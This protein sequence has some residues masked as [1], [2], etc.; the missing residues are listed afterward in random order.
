MK[1]HLG[2]M[3]NV[4]FQSGNLRED[5][6][7]GVLPRRWN[8]NIVTNMTIAGQRLAKHVLALY[9]VN[10]NRRPFLDN[11]FG[12]QGITSVSDTTTVL[13]PL[14]AVVSI[15]FSRKERYLPDRLNESVA[16]S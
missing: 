4:T 14:K 6:H 7:M 15:W 11:G 8:D 3:R 9:T 1:A 2:M 13:E 12:C 10:K 5:D 16:V